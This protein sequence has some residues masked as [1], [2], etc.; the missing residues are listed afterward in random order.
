MKQKPKLDR[1]GV[2]FDLAWEATWIFMFAI[3]IVPIIKGNLY[4]FA[5]A[6]DLPEPMGLLFIICATYGVVMNE[7]YQRLGTRIKQN[8]YKQDE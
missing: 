7:V 4:A 6:I 3:S 1:F 5:K 8:N 2:F